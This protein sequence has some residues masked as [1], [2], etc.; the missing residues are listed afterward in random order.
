M[1]EYSKRK[2]KVEKRKKR[3]LEK[4]KRKLRYRLFLAYFLTCGTIFSSIIYYGEKP[5]EIAVETD[6]QG[7][8]DGRI[9]IDA[10]KTIDFNKLSIIPNLK[11]ILITN[12]EF[13]TDDDISNIN[14]LNL[15]KIYLY[16]DLYNV[17]NNRE[18]KFDLNRFK[19]N[20]YVVNNYD[21]TS[22]TELDY[23]IL[24]NY[25][26]GIK[27]NTFTDS[28][29][30]I[31]CR[32]MDYRI[33]QIISEN[34]LI[35]NLNEISILR[36]SKYI[37]KHLKY[38][39]LIKKEI[40]NNLNYNT[41]KD[42]ARQKTYNYNKKCISTII[43]NENNEAEGICANYQALFDILCYK[44]GIYVRSVNGH[45]I[46]NIND[47]HGWNQVKVNGSDYYVD[48]TN[49]DIRTTAE[50]LEKLDS[51]ISS[52]NDHFYNNIDDF[53]KYNFVPFKEYMSDEI[54]KELKK[55]DKISLNEEVK[56][57]LIF[58]LTLA[59]LSYYCSNKIIDNNEEKNKTLN[60]TKRK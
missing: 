51:N 30:Y 49:F 22:N 20:V 24:Y 38:D 31:N 23:I 44:A 55:V 28:S 37:C 35:D 50:G 48:L 12:S 4:K 25:L 27:E 46:Y 39:E 3:I 8:F 34:D 45:S 1:N 7:L 18:N 9:R 21:I 5:K 41:M 36:I 56:K 26:L 11:S 59:V 54:N 16:F 29:I 17:A 40:E 47:T 32:N 57:I 6:I 52:I 15:E 60:N 53:I 13:L 58:Y 43:Y 19:N 42:E 10:S 14:N 33:N 2:K